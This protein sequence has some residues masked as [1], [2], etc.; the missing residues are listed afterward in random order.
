[1]WTGHAGF[2][3]S[4]NITVGWYIVRLDALAQHESTL[5]CIVTR[6]ATQVHKGSSPRQHAGVLAQCVGS[7]CVAI[8]QQI[9]SIYWLK[10]LAQHVVPGGDSPRERA[11]T[12]LSINITVG[13]YIVRLEA[14]AQ[15]DSKLWC[16]VTRAATQVHK[17]S[18]PRQH[19]GVLA[20]CVGS[21]CVAIAQQ[22]A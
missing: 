20:Q 9:G 7:R 2:D 18:S 14:L 1:V 12:N 16:I 15:H 5:W 19:A 3:L 11:Y 13:W 17:G 6:A 8:A 22:I 21:R 4:I 10:V